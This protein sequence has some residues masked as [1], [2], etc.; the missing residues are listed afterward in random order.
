MEAGHAVPPMQMCCAARVRAGCVLAW[1]QCNMTC[2][3]QTQGPW[4]H[5]LEEACFESAVTRSVALGRMQRLMVRRR[6]YHAISRASCATGIV[7]IVTAMDTVV[8][9]DDLVRLL[10]LLSHSCCLHQGHLKEQDH[11]ID[12]MRRMHETHTC[13]EVMMKMERWIAEHRQEPRRSRCGGQGGQGI[14]PALG[15]LLYSAVFVPPA[16]TPTSHLAR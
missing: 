1:T 11:L 2:S 10:T 3:S 6:A 14:V 8:H 15:C 13:E 7:W 12:Y 5:W 9:F 16:L 4:A